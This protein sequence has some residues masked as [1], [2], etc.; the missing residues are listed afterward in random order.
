MAKITAP[1][2]GFSGKVVG[3]SFVD[4]VGETTDPRALDYFERQEY[5]IEGCASA[6]AKASTDG[7]PTQKDLQARA[8]ELGLAS[9]GTKAALAERIAEAEAA[10]AAEAKSKAEAEATAK[11]A[12]DEAAAAGTGDAPTPD[13]SAE[14][15]GSGDGGSVRTV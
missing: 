1:V 4:G 15:S 10:E 6:P 7:E 2:K 5:G 11:A 9:G 8:K 12:A 3:V 14:P 13:A